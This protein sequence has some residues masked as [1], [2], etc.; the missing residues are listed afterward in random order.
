M[1]FKNVG[2]K[3]HFFRDRFFYFY[4][5]VIVQKVKK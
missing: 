1:K 5:D 4:D 3:G 2:F